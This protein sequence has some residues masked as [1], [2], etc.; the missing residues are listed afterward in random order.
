MADPDVF[1][2]LYWTLL[3]A[4]AA[5]AADL[6]PP[7]P[8]RA[9]FVDFVECWPDVLPCQECREH[10]ALVLQHE[11]GRGVRAGTM[12]PLR[13]AHALH[14]AVNHKLGARSL[15]LDT[16]R[17]RRKVLRYPLE[18]TLDLL[19]ITAAFLPTS[20]K[21][22]PLVRTVVQCTDYLTQSHA[23]STL[24]LAAPWTTPALL[25]QVDASLPLL[26]GDTAAHG[27]TAEARATMAGGTQW[28]PPLTSRLQSVA[29][30]A[31]QM[32]G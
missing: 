13:W 14:A 9:A 23:L 1:G 12:C 24:R 5:R 30:R 28:P 18:N 17:K 6:P 31:I 7:H 2:P 3:E 26:H 29:R 16:V 27:T 4:A 8:L 25:R 21:L 11:P 22:D 32:D 10:F 20:A 19:A 15:S